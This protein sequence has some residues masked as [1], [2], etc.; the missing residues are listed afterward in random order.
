M[1]DVGFDKLIPLK[2]FTD[3]SN[4]YLIEDKCVFGAEVFV[5]KERRT[6]QAECLSRIK[7]PSTYKHVWKLEIFSKLNA[8]SY[9]SE[10]FSVAGQK[11]YL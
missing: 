2:E 8:E 9:R 10:P 11:W 5:W 6:A 7:W 3:A 1:L 4:G